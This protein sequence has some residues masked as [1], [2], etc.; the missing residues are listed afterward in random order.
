EPLN[1]LS[2]VFDAA[3]DPVR[4]Y[5]R[6][7]GQVPLLSADD[8]VRLAKAINKGMEAEERLSNNGS[9]PP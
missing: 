6:E 8:E 1:D 7:I 2:N 5:L 4:M 9:L 3:S